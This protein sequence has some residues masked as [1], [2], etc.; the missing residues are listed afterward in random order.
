MLLA[1]VIAGKEKVF[2][3]RPS[4]ALVEGIWDGGSVA[5]EGEPEGGALVGTLATTQTTDLGINVTRTGAL[6]ALP[7]RS[8]FLRFTLTTVPSLALNF[9]ID[10]IDGSGGSD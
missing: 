4:K 8:T 5:G 7:L 3:E 9:L 1:L 6:T 2:A 10:G